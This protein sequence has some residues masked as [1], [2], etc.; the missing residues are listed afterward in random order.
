MRVDLLLIK[1][2]L[3]IHQIRHQLVPF[4]SPKQVETVPL[5]NSVTAAL[6]IRF[7]SNIEYCL[8]STVH[9]IYFCIL[10]FNDTVMMILHLRLLNCDPNVNFRR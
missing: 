4:T 9:L 1:N 5:L 8:V 2:S 6:Y 10:F 7:K 3:Q